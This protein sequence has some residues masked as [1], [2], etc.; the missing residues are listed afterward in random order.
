MNI[1]LFETYFGGSH[2]SWIDNLIKFSD[3][4]F[5]V[6][7]LPDRYWKWRMHGG[8]ITLAKQI[9][10]QSSIPDLIITT[11]MTDVTVLKSFLPKRWSAVPIHLYFHENQFAYKWST[12]DRDHKSNRKDHYYFIQYVSALAADKVFFN[13]LYNQQTFNEGV[14]KLLKS[15]PENKNLETIE[16]IKLKS[17]VLPLGLDW[18]LFDKFEIQKHNNEDTIILW[19]HRWEEDK[20]PAEFFSILEKLKAIKFRFKLLVLGDEKS[21]NNDFWL[22]QKKLFQK[23]IIHWG[24]VESYEDYIKM[25]YKADLAIVTSN[26][27]FFGLSILESTYAKVATLLPNRLAYPEHFS[28]ETFNQ[29]F[30]HSK[31]ELFEKILNWQKINTTQAKEDISKYRIQSVISLYNDT[32]FSY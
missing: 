22:E 8:A 28:S 5:K 18:D 3:H 24:R 7:S 10:S 29:V 27:D 12:I 1:A 25:L 19:N 16:E 11:S 21:A 2:K 23:E 4:Q 30:Y 31:E 9:T 26:H 32:I 6:Y 15:M 20:N 17:S 14:V 13:S